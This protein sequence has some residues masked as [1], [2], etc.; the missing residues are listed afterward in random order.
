MELNAEVSKAR[1]PRS[2][3]DKV[4]TTPTRNVAV[5]FDNSPG[6]DLRGDHIYWSRKQ[7]SCYTSSLAK[8]VRKE[9]EFSSA[10]NI[11]LT[12]DY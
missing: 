12:D 6:Y 1:F 2:K 5:L 7:L 3:E 8:F 11:F 10:T 9:A 4:I